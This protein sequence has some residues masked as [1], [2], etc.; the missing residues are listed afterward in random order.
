M[1]KFISY[2]ARVITL[3]T[4]LGLLYYV[5]DGDFVLTHDNKKTVQIC[6]EEAERGCPLLLEA[7]EEKAAE[8]EALRGALKGLQEPQTPSQI[9]DSGL[10]QG[11]SIAVGDMVRIREDQVY[12]QDWGLGIVIGI[13]EDFYKHPKLMQFM[14]RVK[15]YWTVKK[16]ESYEPADGLKII[17]KTVKNS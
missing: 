17:S 3:A 4:L 7:L 11:M 15:V 6:I 8:A 2:T 10:Q 12:Q 16:L 13:D 1:R 9:L 5:I 14:P